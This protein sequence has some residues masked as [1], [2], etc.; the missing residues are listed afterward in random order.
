MAERGLESRSPESQP[1]AY[2]TR[3][4]RLPLVVSW[5]SAWA[6]LSSFI[7]LALGFPPEL[8]LLGTLNCVLWELASLPGSF[9]ITSSPWCCSSG[10][11]TGHWQRADVWSPAQGCSLCLLKQGEGGEGK[12]SDYL[13]LDSWAPHNL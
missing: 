3:L 5:F 9:L 7:S 4:H 1:C 2:S 13:G 12:A 10:P 6:Q 11:A 8:T